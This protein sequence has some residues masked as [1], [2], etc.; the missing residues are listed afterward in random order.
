MTVRSLVLTSQSRNRWP[1][2][3][4]ISPHHHRLHH[5]RYHQWQPN[6]HRWQQSMSTST[7]TCS[8][9]RWVRPYTFLCSN[10]HPFRL[11]FRCCVSSTHDA[12]PFHPP[13]SCKACW[14]ALILFPRTMPAPPTTNESYDLLVSSTHNAGPFHLPTSCKAHWWAFF[15]CRHPPTSCKAHW[16]PFFRC[17]HPPC[18][19]QQVIRLVGGLSFRCHAQHW[20]WPPTNN[21]Y[22]SIIVFFFS[23]VFY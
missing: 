19:H 6:S 16:S 23:F 12:G 22:G 11:F 15:H 14:W 21:P 13:M 1:P 9:S 10:S 17:C 4:T 8:W 18:H 2:T 5:H 20:P 3:H 7:S